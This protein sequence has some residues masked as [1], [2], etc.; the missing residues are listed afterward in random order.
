[1]KLFRIYLCLIALSFSYFGM[2][3]DRGASAAPAP[4]PAPAYAFPSGLPVLA[5]LH[6][7]NGSFAPIPVG[8]SFPA[9]QGTGLIIRQPGLYILMPFIHFYEITQELSQLKIH[10]SYFSQQNKTEQDYLK[11]QNEKLGKKNTDLMDENKKLKSKL[12][13]LKKEKAPK[14]DLRRKKKRSEKNDAH[15]V[16]V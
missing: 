10:F 13:A 6:M 12:E 4:A 1:M 16:D 5:D 2:S 11:S 3:A 8:F 15:I 14:A 9:G 7:P